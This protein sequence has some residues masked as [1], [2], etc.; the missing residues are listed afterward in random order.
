MNV[1]RWRYAAASV[2][3]TSHLKLGSPCQDANDCQLLTSLGDAEILVAVLSDGAGTAEHSAEGSALTCSVLMGH[4]VDHIAGGNTIAQITR[5]VVCSWMLNLQG[6]IAT[7][8]ETTGWS[9]REYACTA[10]A[11]VI[12]ASS[13]AFLQIGDGAIVVSEQADEYAHVFW[14]DRGEYENTTYFVTQEAA[15]DHLQF[16]SVGHQ[17]HEAALFTDGIQRLA[18]DYKM[19]VP[20]QPF[21]RSIFS[22]LRATAWGRQQSL[23]TALDQFLGSSRVTDRTDDDKTLVIASRLA[24]TG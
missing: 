21:F 3:G 6:Q 1:G 4:V 20:H 7:N 14:P 17:I 23:C 11:A 9:I 16:E 10:I 24:A 18:L 5:D 19:E 8:A 13:A 12:G 2:I 15:I 22:P